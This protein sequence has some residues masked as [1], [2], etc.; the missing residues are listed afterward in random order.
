MQ[1]RF[2]NI[3]SFLSFSLC[4]SFT[5]TYAS[6]TRIMKLSEV[7][8]G[9]LGVC[10]TVFQGDSIEEFQVEIIGTLKNFFPKK[11]IILARLSGERIEY[12]GLVA[13]MSGSPVYLDG[14]LV[15]AIAYG[16]SFSKE[17]ITGITPIEQMLE[18]GMEAAE[19]PG[20]GGAARPGEGRAVG[21]SSGEARLYDPDTPPPNPLLDRD[22]RLLRP[23][24]GGYAGGAPA[25]TRLEIPLVFSGCHPE[26]F[27]SY[28]ETFRRFGL[29]P[30][31]GGGGE[32]EPHP[33]K[34]PLFEAGSPVS[35]QLVRG[36]LSLAATGTV[37][38]RDSSRVLAF[39]HPFMSM[40]PVDFPMTA[41]EIVTV[42]PSLS[43]SFKLSNST[44]FIG[45]V[46]DDHMNG[47]RAVVGGEPAMIP[48]SIE[49]EAAGRPSLSY[50]YEM[51][52]QK[53]LTPLLGGLIMV[54]SLMAS[55][56]AAFEQTI[57]LS[58]RLELADTGPVIIEDMYAGI[59]AASASSRTLQTA[60]LYLY[61]NPYGPAEIERIDLKLRL[62]EGNPRAGI[63]EVFLDRST[64]YPGDTLN[65]EVHLNPY[66]QPL[67]REY[68]SLAVPEDRAESD[69]FILVGSGEMITRT[70]MQLS[71]NRFRYTSLEHLVR[72]IND[73]RRNNYLY[74]KVFRQD[75][76][77]I[78]GDQMLPGL[79][80][81]VWSLLKSEKTSGAAL[82]L[83][84]FTV[85]ETG[86][87]TGFIINGFKIM[88]VEVKPRP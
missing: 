86:R 32:N 48:L 68:F 36:D 1:K 20:G 12:T 58:G 83:A 37:T 30:L 11:D 73:S 24:A 2:F 42:M 31:M 10:R 18:I 52:R 34:P 13:G 35:A 82:P 7:Q 75:K 49:L 67:I 19:S 8:P 5:S 55:G 25:L 76:G 85:A 53:M 45:T 54:N 23:T 59:D 41:A 61:N 21:S 29:V 60:L 17:P 84:D 72:L 28:G 22:D 70:E 33:G 16:W 9:M 87:P 46:T 4:A 38:Y 62:S 6:D 88:H 51:I 77:L 71:P 79:P 27:N 57:E 26:V 50:H 64:V 63:S 40:G 39:G 66:T 15:G 80:P 74:V 65:L 81:S 3:F 47:I 43:R 69:L 56:Q 44:G 78:M 14:G